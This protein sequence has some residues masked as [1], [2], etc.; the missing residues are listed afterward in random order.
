[1]SLSQNKKEQ[2]QL[3]RPCRNDLKTSK[4]TPG[5][6]LLSKNSNSPFAIVKNKPLITNH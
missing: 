6:T 3:N 5:I 4:N 1:M 2:D